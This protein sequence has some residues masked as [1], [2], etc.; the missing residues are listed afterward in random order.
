MNVEEMSQ[1]N[2]KVNY[3]GLLFKKYVANEYRM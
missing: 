1:A 3:E 2:M